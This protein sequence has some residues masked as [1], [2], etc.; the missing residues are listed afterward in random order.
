MGYMLYDGT[1]R[2]EF[3]DRVLAHLQVV[4]VN[5]LRRQ[6]SFIMSWKEDQ[7]T[8]G[9]RSSIWLDASLPLRFHFDGSKAPQIDRE[10][11]E[12]LLESAASSTGL[13]VVDEAGEPLAGRLLA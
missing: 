12:Q 10:W 5:K 4:I 3:E 2:I 1:S 7:S 9:G 8:G 13:I 6:E 11:I